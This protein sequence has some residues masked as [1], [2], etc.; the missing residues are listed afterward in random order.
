MTDAAADRLQ[1]AMTGQVRSALFLL[2]GAVSFLLLVACANVANLLLAQAARRERELAIRAAL[3]ADRRRLIWQFLMEAALLCGTGGMIGVFAA[4]W[5]VDAL[6]GLA[7]K[8]LP[9]L[10]SVSLN[11]PVFYFCACA[12]CWRRAWA[13]SPRLAPRR[14]TSASRSPK[15]ASSKPAG[16]ANNGSAGRLSPVSSR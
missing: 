16:S 14:E 12:F 15:A 4:R 1:V 5:G 3:G 8:E 10:D 6:V 2:L 9:R 7:P 13:S 11:L